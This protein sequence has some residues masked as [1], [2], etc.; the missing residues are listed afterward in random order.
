MCLDL[1]TAEQVKST[2][3]A[4]FP[5]LDPLSFFRAWTLYTFYMHHNIF[6]W[7]QIYCTRLKLVR[8]DGFYGRGGGF[9]RSQGAPHSLHFGW[10]YSV[11][12]LI[13]F[14]DFFSFCRDDMYVVRKIW[15]LN[16]YAA[17]IF[18]SDGYESSQEVLLAWFPPHNQQKCFFFSSK[19]LMVGFSLRRSR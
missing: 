2:N 5:L 4:K 12:F 11:I 6:I 8:C 17:C 7:I 1:S 18:A 15:F 14:Y 13:D 9:T 19:P 3:F 16:N 10:L